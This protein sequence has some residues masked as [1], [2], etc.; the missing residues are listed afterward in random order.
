MSQPDAVNNNIVGYAKGGSPALCS[1]AEP[2]PCVMLTH[3]VHVS[4]G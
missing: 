3:K 2:G 4:G 1:R